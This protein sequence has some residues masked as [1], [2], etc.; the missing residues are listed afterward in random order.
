MQSQK[1][2]A[3]HFSPRLVIAGIWLALVVTGFSILSSYA[4]QPGGKAV[5][6]STWPTSANENPTNTLMVFIHPR[7]PCTRATIEELTWIMSRCHRK[8][9]CVVMPLQPDGCSEGWS[10]ASLVRAAAA[11][12]GVRIE[13]DRN[14]VVAKR[15][16]ARTSGH[17][18]LFDAA[19]QLIFEGGITPSRGHQ[20]HSRGHDAIL[21]FVDQLH[22]EKQLPGEK[23]RTEPER[24][25]LGLKQPQH[26]FV[27]GCPLFADEGAIDTRRPN[28]AP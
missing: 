19:G 26:E 3:R 9:D 17:C 20:G 18:I 24:R 15:F 11:A 7:C 8:L 1:L 21:S 6:P 14:G 27:F 28:Q 22:S 25:D 13:T 16:G 23:G 10:D 4:N 2:F 12:P 5:V